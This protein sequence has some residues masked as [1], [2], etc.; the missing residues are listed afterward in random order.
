MGQDY[1]WRTEILSRLV[2][3]DMFSARHELPMTALVSR[4]LLAQAVLYSAVMLTA[5]VRVDW[6]RS[7]QT[8]YVASQVTI[9]VI[10]TVLFLGPV[11]ISWRLMRRGKRASFVPMILVLGLDL[12]RLISEPSVVAIVMATL[13]TACVVVVVQR[14]TRS[15]LKVIAKRARAPRF[16]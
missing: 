2:V 9:L 5:T 11:W 13:S 10:T 6:P 1:E 16:K 12:F 14:R 3:S 4:I 15:E 7:V 8:D